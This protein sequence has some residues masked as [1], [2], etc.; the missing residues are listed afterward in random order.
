MTTLEIVLASSL[1]VIYLALLFTVVVIT[2]R[3]GHIALFVIGVFIPILWLIDAVLPANW[4]SIYRTGLR[5]RSAQ[6]AKPPAIVA[7]VIGPT[8]C[9]TT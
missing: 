8:L 3:K 2:F 4:Q 1:F 6:V 9:S 5:P 7:T